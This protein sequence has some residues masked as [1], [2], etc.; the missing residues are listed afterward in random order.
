MFRRDFIAQPSGKG[1][2]RRPDAY[3]NL[4]TNHCEQ[5]FEARARLDGVWLVR[6]KQYGVS[7]PCLKR[8]AGDSDF[9][10]AFKHL[11]Q[12]IEWR[13]VF[14]KTL[15]FIEGEHGYR[16]CWALQQSTADHGPN[17]EINQFSEPH[18][19]RFR[20]FSP[21]LCLLCGHRLPTRSFTGPA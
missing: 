12:C 6:R 4:R 3:T 18:Y 14:A 5:H 11:N 21:G 9:G 20:H 13:C 1:A 7:S 19:F 17:L 15:P 2:G 16:S 10:A 8:L